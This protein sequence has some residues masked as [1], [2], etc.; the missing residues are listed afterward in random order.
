[1]LKITKDIKEATFVT[2]AG[3]FHADD[4]FATVFLHKLYDNITVIRLKSY[5]P[6]NVCLGLPDDDAQYQSKPIDF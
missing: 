3:N 2:H 5:I 6:E 4:V 1:M